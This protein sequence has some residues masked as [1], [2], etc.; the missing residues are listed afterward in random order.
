MTTAIMTSRGRKPL[1]HELKLSVVVQTRA[2]VLEKM[3][4]EEMAWRR[5][6]TISEIVRTYL[7]RESKKEFG[8]MGPVEPGT[9]MPSIPASS[10]ESP[11]PSSA[12]PKASRAPRAP[13]AAPAKRGKKTSS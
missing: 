3:R 9:P 11:A 2:T 8:H 4:W 6:T 5:R 13:K 7:N 12:S 10:S 1:P